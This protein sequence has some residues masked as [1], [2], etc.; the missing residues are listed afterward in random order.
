MPWLEIP[1]GVKH[2]HLPSF[3]RSLHPAAIIMWQSVS[4]CKALEAWAQGSWWA[5][6]GKMVAP[7]PTY[8]W[9]GEGRTAER[10][11]NV[12]RGLW[13]WA[14][15][16]HLAFRLW[17]GSVPALSSPA[18]KPASQPASQQGLSLKEAWIGVWLL[19]FP[20]LLLITKWDFLGMLYAKWQNSRLPLTPIIP[21]LTAEGRTIFLISPPHNI[22][23]SS[24]KEIRPLF[25]V[26]PSVGWQQ[27]FPFAETEHQLQ[28][29]KGGWQWGTIWSTFSKVEGQAG[30]VPGA[31]EWHVNL[32]LHLVM[33]CHRP[34]TGG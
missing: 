10:S 30:I 7:L 15:T 4:I 13:P 34:S 28:N 23:A 20:P 31:L 24:L 9:F 27:A 17:V 32:N 19:L 26:L 25:L 29:E 2:D 8:L 12:H 18:N 1:V 14:L 5:I 22:P 21:L 3:S 16:S 6:R 33:R 11:Y